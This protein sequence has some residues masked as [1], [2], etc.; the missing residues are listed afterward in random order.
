MS[1][2]VALRL[3]WN[4]NVRGPKMYNPLT[5]NAFLPQCSAAA[6]L[7]GVPTARLA[8]ASPAIT[9]LL[10]GWRMFLVIVGDLVRFFVLILE[11]CDEL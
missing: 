10:V 7:P 3:L 6:P 4:Q 11:R 9:A 2:T 1:D 8:V 5:S